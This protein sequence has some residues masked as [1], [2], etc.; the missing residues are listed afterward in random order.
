MKLGYAIPNNQGVEKVTDLIAL[1]CEAERLGFDSVWVSEHLFNTAYV[2]KRLGNRPYHEALTVL[3]AV[4]AATTTVQLGTSVLVLPWHHPVRLGKMIASLDQFSEGRVILGVGVGITRD[5]YDA[6]GVSFTKRGQI[7]N[8]CL[9]AMKALWTQELPEFKG[10]HYAFSGQL[11]S[12]KPVNNDGPPIWIGGNSAAAKKRLINYGTG[13]HP[14]AL[15]PDELREA[16]PT[17]RTELEAARRSSA[18]PV[19]LRTTLEITDK[20]WDRPPAQRRTLKGTIPE[21]I[22]MLQAYQ[23]AGATHLIIDPNSGDVGYNRE[24]L[25]Q[26]AEDILPHLG[27]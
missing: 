4:A 18:I 10:E 14:L 9:A 21:L 17:L 8:E 23:Q 24:V 7:A 16:L 19:A 15:S 6:L 26:V 13:W 20:P 27:G 22:E 11:F 3:T 25:A 1:A 5:E 2:A 12:P